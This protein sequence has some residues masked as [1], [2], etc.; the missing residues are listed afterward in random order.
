MSTNTLLLSIYL[1]SLLQ[2]ILLS[3]LRFMRWLTKE[4]SSNL[5][6]TQITWMEP[7]S[8]LDKFYD[9]MQASYIPNSP[10]FPIQSSAK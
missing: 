10:I 3:Y 6:S 8:C 4:D 7:R 2:Q 1:V 9:L 5:S